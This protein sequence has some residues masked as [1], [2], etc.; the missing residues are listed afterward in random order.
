[1]PKTKSS[2]KSINNNP[3]TDFSNDNF[4]TFSPNYFPS[5]TFKNNPSPAQNA[6]SL[7]CGKTLF[8]LEDDSRQGLRSSFH[9]LTNPF[10]LKSAVKA[11]FLT[12]E[13]D[14]IN[15][16]SLIAGGNINLSA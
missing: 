7:F 2:I 5:S 9:E 11:D 14:I 4:C 12:L 10:S 8:C 6:S 1:M 15:H 13:P 16:G 3:L